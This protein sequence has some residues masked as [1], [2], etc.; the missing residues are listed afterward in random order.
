VADPNPLAQPA[1]LF[2]NLGRGR[3]A[4]VTDAAGGAF[5]ARAV[6]RGLA[7]GDL[8][9]DGDVDLVVATAEAPA[10]LWLNRAGQDAP[11][12][13]LRLLTRDGR[14]DALGARVV[15]RRR[16]A[17]DLLRHAHADG[18][19]ASAS[20]PR[21]LFGLGGGTEVTGVEVT[22]PD[23]A[24]EAFDAP[25]LRGYTVLRQGTGRPAPRGTPR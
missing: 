24:R 19:Y 14:R 10:R 8:D 5:R 4:D 21:V 18:S 2:R 12:S 11:W 3:F 16:G 6:A 15:L 20:D 1:Q 17:P 13:G 25:P 23:G 9:D 7:A 22:W